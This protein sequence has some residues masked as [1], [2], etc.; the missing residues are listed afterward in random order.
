MALEVT[1]LDVAAAVVLWVTVL[2]AL[3]RWPGAVIWIGP[4]L[5][6]WTVAPLASWLSLV[7][8]SIA[9][10]AWRVWG[11]GVRPARDSMQRLLHRPALAVMVVSAGVSALAPEPLA[12][13]AFA[14]LVVSTAA[15]AVSR[16]QQSVA[17]NDQQSVA[18]AGAGRISGSGEPNAYERVA[19]RV[20]H[21]FAW[22]AGVRCGGVLVATVRLPADSSPA[23]LAG[24]VARGG[25]PT[26]GARLVGPGTRHTPGRAGCGSRC[27][28][29]R[30]GRTSREGSP[31]GHP[32]GR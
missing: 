30:R 10:L 12:P 19:G 1:V 29:V 16:P 31:D 17:V 28:R 32:E 15:V 6:L 24:T 18:G 7:V 4:A 27:R 25:C 23:D 2:V 8:V 9:S 20:E 5:A 21:V 14:L 13:V 26:C 11:R 3:W 22:V